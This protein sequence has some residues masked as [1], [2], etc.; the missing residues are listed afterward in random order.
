M[1]IIYNNI[2]PFKGYKAI[3]LFGV[4]F[5]RKGCVLSQQDIN[6]EKIHTAQMRELMYVGFYVWYLLE[7]LYRLTKKGNAYWNISFEQEAYGKQN[8][9]CYLT[10]RE[11]YAWKKYL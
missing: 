8:D 9:M 10:K 5:A 11:R 4:L 6:H 1:R 7:W 3:N 2:I